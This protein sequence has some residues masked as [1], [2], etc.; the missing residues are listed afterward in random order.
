MCR[1]TYCKIAPPLLA[2]QQSSI[3]FKGYFLQLEIFVIKSLKGLYVL[4]FQFL[5]LYYIYC[6]CNLIFRKIQKNGQLQKMSDLCCTIN[7]EG[8]TA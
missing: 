4:Y 3:I 8:T 6:D 5:Q 7:S 2:L 1:S